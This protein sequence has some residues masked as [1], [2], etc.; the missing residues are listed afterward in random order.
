[1]DLCEIFYVKG[2]GEKQY[3]PNGPAVLYFGNIIHTFIIREG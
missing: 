3:N 2:S 1:M